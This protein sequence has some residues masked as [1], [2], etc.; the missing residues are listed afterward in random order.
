MAEKISPDIAKPG[1]KLP[2]WAIWAISAVLI[3]GGGGSIAYLLKGAQKPKEKPQM[4]VKSGLPDDYFTQPELIKPPEPPKE[5]PKPQTEG[6]KGPAAPVIVREVKLTANDFFTARPVPANPPAPPVDPADAENE[7]RRGAAQTRVARPSGA[8]MPVADFINSQEKWNEEQEIAS[9]PVN[10][11]RVVTVDRFIRATLINGINSELSGKVVAQIDEN[12]Y[13]AHGNKVLVPAGSKAVGRYKANL[14]PGEERIEMFWSRLITPDGINIHLG[15]AEMTD[16]MGRSGITGEVDNRFFD[17]YGMALLV[18]TIGIAG[19]IAVP[20]TNQ[21]QAVIVQQ[22]GSATMNLAQQILD[23][24]INLKPKVN[25]APG[26]PILLSPTKDIWFKKP[27]KR[28]SL[29]VALD[30]LKGALK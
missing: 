19:S 11:E 4:V 28:D 8:M 26:A 15:D 12:I 13:G 22:Y 29:A 17:R 27:E 5:E 2:E 6:P 18:S 3:I 16:A 23:K 30:N 14:K 24:N 7:A 20:V 9:F 25:I 21:G 1:K 10:L